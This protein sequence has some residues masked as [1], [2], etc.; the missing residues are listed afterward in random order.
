MEL[1]ARIAELIFGVC[2]NVSSRDGRLGGALVGCGRHVQ[3]PKRSSAD[4]SSVSSVS[5]IEIV[6]L[7]CLM[8][9]APLTLLRLTNQP[10]RVT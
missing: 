2:F 1:G 3:S 6:T 9:I 7:P 4:R 10:R 5:G 8:V